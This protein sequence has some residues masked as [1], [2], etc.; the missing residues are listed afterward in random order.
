MLETRDWRAGIMRLVFAFGAVCGTHRCARLRPPSVDGPCTASFN[1]VE[2]SR[3]DSLDSP[4][5]TGRQATSSPSTA[6]MRPAPRTPGSRWCWR[7]SPSATP[8]PP[9]DRS[10][11]SSRPRSISTTSRPTGWACTGSTGITDNCTVEAWVRI[12][13]RFPFATLTG[14]TAGGLALGG[15]AAQMTAIAT[16]AAP[17]GLAAALGGLVTGTGLAGIGQ[18]FGKMQLS[19]PSVADRGGDRCRHRGGRR[20]P[21]LPE[22]GTGIHRQTQ[23]GQGPEAI[24]PLSGPPRSSPTRRRAPRSRSG[25]DHGPRR[26]QPPSEA[27]RSRSCRTRRRPPRPGTEPS[28]GSRAPPR[29]PTPTHPAVTQNHNPRRR[30]PTADPVTPTPQPSGDRPDAREPS[31]PIDGPGWCYVLAPVDVFDLADHTRTVGVLRPG[32][33]Y[34]AKR[35]VGAWVQVAA[36]DGVDGWVAAIGHPP[37]RLRVPLKPT[38]GV[39]ES[40]LNGTEPG[41]EVRR[42]ADGGAGRPDDGLHFGCGCRRVWRAARSPPPTTPSP[43]PEIT[44][45]EESVPTST[46]P[47]ITARPIEHR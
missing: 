41:R 45:S 5:G 39:G 36:G 31:L 7:W 34:L 44:R 6:P 3:I 14:L 4:T 10:R 19:I 35:Q 33:W 25:C 40:S 9:T 20:T 42:A 27:A 29:C 32:N 21:P 17:V 1:G 13:G 8:P 23:D 26:R 24:H 46:V 15:F 2:S 22:R 47:D 28:T 30:R 37:P 16:T 11:T 12:S 43:L 38:P 18:Q